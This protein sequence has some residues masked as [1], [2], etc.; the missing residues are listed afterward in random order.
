[1]TFNDPPPQLSQEG[2]KTIAPLSPSPIRIKTQDATW[3]REHVFHEMERE[4]QRTQ[5]RYVHELL[6]LLREK[7]QSNEADS[8]VAEVG[9]QIV[10]RLEPLVESTIANDDTLHRW[11]SRD[12]V[13]DIR[14]CLQ[15]AAAKADHRVLVE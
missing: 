8:D 12:E 3:L 6:N 14:A 13:E 7:I 10:S 11:W 9:Q 1:V 4:D 5:A 15:Y 2:C